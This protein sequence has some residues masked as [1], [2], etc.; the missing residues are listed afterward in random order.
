MT[1]SRGEADQRDRQHAAARVPPQERP[2]RIYWEA[3]L[4]LVIRPDAAS[5]QHQGHL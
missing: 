3:E 5:R 2:P 4:P 1:A